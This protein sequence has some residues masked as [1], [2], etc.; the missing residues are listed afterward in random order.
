MQ[1][2]AFHKEDTYVPLKKQ[3]EMLKT[4]DLLYERGLKAV[5]KNIPISKVRNG[6]LYGDIIK[7]KY[8]VPND[9]LERL[10]ELKNEINDFYNTLELDY[11][12]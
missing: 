3:L 9:N 1:Q 8:S 11:S 2:N 12:K 10:E 4:I 6:E 7:M 5:K